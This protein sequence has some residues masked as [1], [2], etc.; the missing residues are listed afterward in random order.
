[1]SIKSEI[2]HKKTTR[3]MGALHPTIGLQRDHPYARGTRLKP[4][5]TYTLVRNI[6]ITYQNFNNPITRIFHKVSPLE[7]ST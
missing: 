2:Y 6:Y 4:G 7:S 5:F 1:M 3:T